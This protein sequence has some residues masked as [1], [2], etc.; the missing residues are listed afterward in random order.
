[1]SRGGG[2]K[3]RLDWQLWDF[4]SPGWKKGRKRQAKG[5]HSMSNTFV[6]AFERQNAAEKK[7]TPLHQAEGMPMCRMMS[8]AA[9]R[10]EEDHF[11]SQGQRIAVKSRKGIASHRAAIKP[12]FCWREGFCLQGC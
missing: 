10:A 9:G 2:K 12:D 11:R 7:C 6:S 5:I 8:A 4:G 1:M 3:R